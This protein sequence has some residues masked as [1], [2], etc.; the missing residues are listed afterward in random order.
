VTPTVLSS[1]ATRN[2]VPAYGTVSV[3]VRVWTWQE[4]Q[5]VDRAM[6]ALRPSLSGARLELVGGPN[7]PPFERCASAALFAR[8]NVIAERIGI[9]PLVSA[10]VGGASDGN[11]TAGRAVPTLDGLGAVG[12]GAH[13]DHEHVLV[14]ELLVRTELIAGLVDDLLAS[15]PTDPDGVERLEARTW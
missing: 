11:F 6:R 15:E 10:A 13:A 5:R 1:G 2:T 9:A 7:R 14:E 3:D 12:G 8:A 4:Q